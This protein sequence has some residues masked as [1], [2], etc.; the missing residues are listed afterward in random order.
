MTTSV[1]LATDGAE[2]TTVV[3]P[4]ET[5]QTLI[6]EQFPGSSL[7][8]NEFDNTMLEFCDTRLS[9]DG[10]LKIDLSKFDIVPRMRK[11]LRPKLRTSCAPARDPSAR[12]GLASLIKR[13]FGV[14]YVASPLGFCAFAKKAVEKM[15]DTFC[16]ED[17]R[18]RI[19]TFD[20][21]LPTR[22]NVSVWLAA[23]NTAT[24]ANLG[25]IEWNQAQADL[26]DAL[27]VYNLILKS[28]PKVAT[29][30][31]PLSVVPP[32]QTIMFHPKYANAYFGPVIREADERFRGL[33]KPQVLVNKGKNLDQIEA[34]LNRAYDGGVGS[35][36]IE[37]DFSDYDRSQAELALFIDLVVLELMGVDFDILDRWLKSH[38][39]TVNVSHR[40]GLI[41]YIWMQRKSGDVM[42]SDGNTRY[43]MTSLAWALRL[44][45]HELIC[46]M[47][48]GDD[49]FFQVVDSESL[50]RRVSLCSSE[51]GMVFNAT[52]K[53]AYYRIGYFCGYYILLLP[54][55][56]KVAAD[57]WRK[58]VKL[59]R[60][61][62]AA[63]ADL[64][65]HWVS[66]GDTT[67]NYDRQDVQEALVEACAERMPRAGAVATGAL[68]A[69]LN[70]LRKSYKEFVNFWE[71]SVTTTC[72]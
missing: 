71:S 70:S 14:D 52:A 9:V 68:V 39:N 23:Q 3:A 53:T 54:D 12:A 11:S 4:L 26:D 58:A 61:D 43:N 29:D 44:K 63:F 31:K 47:F 10:K 24:L 41:V 55:G 46:A 64:K 13:N 51:L 18:Q 8:D 5:I 50:R 36:N 40:L 60:W 72:Y 45:P 22:A 42:T 21:I 38:C 34:F 30:D 6:D 37:N 19:L 1:F 48:L 69:S 57:P 67:R 28:M 15:M 49:S 65:E 59:G 62:V 7:I 25:R 66:F 32:V 16:V 35:L 33:L 20:K 17:W 2:G 56:V 27:E